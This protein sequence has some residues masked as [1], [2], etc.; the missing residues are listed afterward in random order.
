MDNFNI[1]FT[2]QAVFIFNL[3][4]GVTGISM[5]ALSA[6][7]YTD[8]H[9]FRDF[10]GEY[11]WIAPFFLISAGGI[12]FLVTALCCYGTIKENSRMIQIFMVLLAWLFFFEIA[13]AVVV[14]VKRNQFNGT[15]DNSFD[16]MLN[17]YE[18]NKEIWAFA[19]T[20]LKCCG[21]NSPKD[22]TQ[23]L[24][25][26]SIPMSCCQNRTTEITD[27]TEEMAIKVGCKA[28]LLTYLERLS[29]MLAG[30]GFGIAWIQIVVVGYACFM[31]NEFQKSFGQFRQR[32][33]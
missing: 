5:L 24:N 10:I 4:F 3:L 21:V 23:T 30:V 18:K 15:L 16:S 31:F 19:Q 27:C 17:N 20:E 11:S 8:Y 9:Q 13:T 2:K 6:L 25:N 26:T 22:W 33:I 7:I 28:L 29:I 32:L 1:I 12:V 14:Y